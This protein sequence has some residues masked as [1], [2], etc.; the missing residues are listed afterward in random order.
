LISFVL[1]LSVMMFM[2]VLQLEALFL[3]ASRP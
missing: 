1:V 3:D 2:F